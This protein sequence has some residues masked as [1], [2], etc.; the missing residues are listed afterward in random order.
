M[1]RLARG[2]LGLAAAG[3]A[4]TLLLGAPPALAA[5]SANLWPNGAAGSRANTE[6]RT[7]SYGNGALTRRT[8]VKAYM[9]AG[10]VLMLGSS[11]MGQGLS[12]IRVYNPNRVTGPIGTETIPALADFSCAAQ[13]LLVGAPP[14]QGIITSRA[15]ELAGPD[16]IPTSGA[17]GYIPCHYAAPSTGIYDISFLGPLGGASNTDGAVA[18]DVALAAAGDFNA[19]Q[20]TSIAAWDATVRAN[21]ASAVNITGRVFTYYLALFTAANGLPVFPSI[22]AVTRDAYRY[23]IDLRGMDPNGWVVYG[24]QVGF[25]DSDGKTPLYHDAVAD[26]TGSPGQLTGI[27]GGVSLGLPSFP[28]FFEPPAAATIAALG[29]PAAPIA[30]IMSAISFAGNVGGN[31]SLVNTGGTFKFT[32]NVPGVYDIVIS[33]DGVDFDPTNPLNRSLRGVVGGAG[34]HT[35]AW[36]G[37]DNSNAAF[38]VGSYEAHVS[39]HGG[40]YH[41]PMIDVENDTAGGPT[42]TM[43][44]APGGVC[45]P[46]TG[47]CS[48]A[49]YD[50]RAYMT[51]NGTVVNSGNA[52]GTV[53]CGT[54]PPTTAASNPITGFN[55]AGVQRAYGTASGGNT[56]VPCTGNF[57]DAKGLDIWTYNL[58]NTVVTPLVIVATAADIQVR[59]SVSDPTP[60]VNSNVTF[61][62]TAKN[63]GPN[64]AT[65]VQVRDLLPAG[66]ALVS[67]TPSQGTYAPG[68]G[69][70][71]IGNL[72]LNATATLRLVVTVLRTTA[73]TNVASRLAGTPGDFNPANNTGRA[74]VTGSTVPGL[75]NTG[76]PPAASWWPGVLAL[77]IA[78]ALASRFAGG[79]SL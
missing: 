7:G 74:T 8:L 61:T 79:Q 17:G 52:V 32:T 38:P 19:T 39:L 48:G 78:L 18:A 57:G 2:R 42:I 9:T 30:P 6:W 24:N 40:E 21:L 75:P 63:L 43:L 65:G 3:S 25:L 23:K 35:V 67:A 27:Q 62:I 5:G 37:L 11:A 44:N 70:W 1:L 20:G 68:T 22:Y 29:I 77:L 36:D 58:S 46:L 47:G 66:L 45:P 16:T 41:F 50:D 69:V 13:R 55:S 10:Q 54:A 51:R 71:V 15:E 49:F 14:S 73:V 56:N 33:R 12:D 53:L 60:A 59:K 72:A 26:A 31:T 64:A 76:V 28:L 4:M 34:I